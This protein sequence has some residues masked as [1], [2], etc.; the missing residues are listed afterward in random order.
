MSF[1]LLEN[2]TDSKSDC[3]VNDGDGKRKEEDR[4]GGG[5][6]ETDRTGSSQD[7]GNR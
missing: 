6:G 2:Q 1:S 4:G 5:G 7:K 3:L